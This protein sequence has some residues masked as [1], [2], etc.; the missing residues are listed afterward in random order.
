MLSCCLKRL[1]VSQDGNVVFFKAK[2]TT[3]LRCV[4]SE[5]LLC[6]VCMHCSLHAL[7]PRA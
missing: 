3:P 6:E 1:H 2:K 4:A 7:R 5:A